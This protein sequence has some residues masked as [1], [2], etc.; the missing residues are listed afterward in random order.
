MIGWIIFAFCFTFTA[1]LIMFLSHV[2]RIKIAAKKDDGSKI[3]VFT[4]VLFASFASL[5]T[6]LLSMLSDDR[7]P[8]P[9]IFVPIVVFGMLIS[10]VMVHTTFTFHYVHLFYDDDELN[11]TSNTSGLDFPGEPTP[12]CID[13]AYLSFVIG[14]TFQVSVVRVRSLKIRRLILLHGLLSFVLNTFGVA[15]TINFIAGLR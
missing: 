12:D 10:W 6:V 7:L 11:N 14:C 15:L 9:M 5:F 4:M 8:Q 13:F 2:E 3:F 1:S